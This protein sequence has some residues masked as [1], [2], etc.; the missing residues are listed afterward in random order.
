MTYY[1]PTTRLGLKGKLENVGRDPLSGV[2]FRGIA[3]NCEGPTCSCCAGVN[4][5]TFNFDR[6][7]CTNFTYFP[8]DFAVNVT[9]MVNDKVL[10]KTGLL[11]AK[12]P[13]PICMPFYL[14][15][16]SFCM[17][18]F[19]IYTSGK[20][21][22]ACMDLET[23]VVNW[24]ILVLH[25]DCVKIGA[26][27]ISWMKPEDFNILHAEV[28]KPEICGPE[29]YDHVDFEPDSTETPSNQTSTLTP[30]EEDHIGQLK[31]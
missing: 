24:P 21:L 2:A 17:R 27:G 15:F 25:F 30:E 31:L 3:C 19:D 8:E 29:E 22:H 18:F 26:D 7:A 20:N 13:E 9:F 14:P 6:R 1:D 12:N 4:I 28:G 11:S 16:I 23:R 5:T 10:L